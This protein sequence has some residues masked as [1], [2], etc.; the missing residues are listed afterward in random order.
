MNC[1]TI[2]TLQNT[3]KIG[4]ATIEKL[5]QLSDFSEINNPSD[6]VDL[7]KKAKK[8]YRRISIPELNT[9]ARAWATSKALMETSDNLGI[10]I[11]SKY[12]EDYPPKL[13]QIKNHPHLLHVKGDVKILNRD[14]IAIVGSRKPTKY[15]ICKAK[16]IASKIVQENYIVV[17]GLAKGIDSIAHGEAITSKGTTIAVLAHGLDLV[18]PKENKKLADDIIKSGGALVSEYPIGTKATKSHF[19]NRNRIQTGL[20]F[21]VIV[22]ESSIKSGTM[23]TAKFCKEQRRLLCVLKPPM[24]LI[25]SP[26]FAGNQKLI[27]DNL[28]E[29]VIGNTNDNDFA[30]KLN[31]LIQKPKIAKSSYQSTLPI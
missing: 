2:L 25:E 10:K 16:E 13:L 7:L 12:C 5:I 29:L 6:I 19:V 22:I 30:K 1:L 31:H 15:G 26:N 4:Y 24:N 11:I 23:H 3:P 18:Y 27:N 14:C 8:T 20:S 21:G 28:V 17:A 9:V